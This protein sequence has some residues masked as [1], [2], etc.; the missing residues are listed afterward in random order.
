MGRQGPQLHLE[1]RP[2]E[3]PCPHPHTACHPLQTN[4]YFPS[5]TLA[6][7]LRL[8]GHEGDVCSLS[9]GPRASNKLATGS[10][11]GTA[12]SG[13]GEE[14]QLRILLALLILLAPLA[15]CSLCQMPE[16]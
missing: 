10:E 4:T 15:A 5:V 3:G 11:D 13:D 14:E 6:C 16:P 8:K 1:V 12:R 7:P 2:H 9:Y